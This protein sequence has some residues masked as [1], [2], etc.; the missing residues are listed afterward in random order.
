MHQIQVGSMLVD[1]V[2][3]DIKNLHLAVYPP[4]GRVRIA[5][6]LKVDDESVRLFAISKLAWIRKQQTKFR[7]QQRQS[8][9][10]YVYRE[11]HYFQGNR[12]LLNII[13]HAAPP[14][15]ILRNK[16]YIDLY[17]REGS[18]QRQ[19]QKVM[20]EW[21]RGRLKE[22]IPPLIEK[23]QNIIGVRVKEWGI[24][25]MKTRWGT[26]NI[27]A[28]RIWLNLELAK[29]PKHCLEYILVHEMLHL[30]ERHHSDRFIAYLDEFIPQWRPYKEELNRFPISHPDWN[31]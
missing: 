23:W 27:K 20:T 2:R 7:N 12:Y 21:Y 1:V 3:K 6:P 24:K 18:S 15:V 19:R 11:S 17:V 9:R 25:Q 29:K 26:C 13:E 31:Y 30:L 4:A 22:Q 16:A 10:E 28:K 5:T 14:K 8:R